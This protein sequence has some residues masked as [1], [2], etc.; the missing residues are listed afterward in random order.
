MSMQQYSRLLSHLRQVVDDGVDETEP[1]SLSLIINGRRVVLT[2]MPDPENQ[3]SDVMCRVEAA[4]LQDGE[5]QDAYRR[6][7]EA[8]LLWRGTRG[9]TLGLLGQDRVVLSVT[10]RLGSLDPVSLGRM[11]EGLVKDAVAWA[12]KL[13]RLGAASLP[14]NAS[15]SP[16]SGGWNVGT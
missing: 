10:W 3:E 7:L 14:K 2:V 5:R 13:E 11:L 4:R 12:A 1:Q 15:N 16:A 6:L 8:N 9:A